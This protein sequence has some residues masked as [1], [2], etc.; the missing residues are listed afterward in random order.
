MQAKARPRQSQETLVGSLA[1]LAGAVGAREALLH[2]VLEV[3][4]VVLHEPGGEL[5]LQAVV[6]GAEDDPTDW[7]VRL[8]HERRLGQ[9]LD[10]EEDSLVR[11]HLFE[12]LPGLP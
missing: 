2:E 7:S 11:R 3:P 5:W 9:A 4:A 10:L 12:E 1:E 6:R 8:Q